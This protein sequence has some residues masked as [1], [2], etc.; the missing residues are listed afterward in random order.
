MLLNANKKNTGSIT[1]RHLH[2][3][4]DYWT[5]RKLLNL[6]L[7]E[8]EKRA[9]VANP[10]SMPYTAT[11]D[12]TNAC[13]LRCPG[14]PTGSGIVGRPKQMLEMEQLDRFL[15]QTG[16]YLLMAHLFNWGESLLHPRIA[17][18]VDRVHR[19]RIFTTISSNLNIRGFDVIARVCDAGLDHLIIS[20]DGATAETY[21]RYRVGGDFE[22]V[23]R[24][25][26][27]I[28]EHRAA[29]GSTRPFLEWQ[30]LS[31]NYLEGEIE[32]ARALAQELG[33]DSFRIKGPTAPERLQ[34]A[35]RTLQ[36][37]FYGGRTRCSLLWHN[38]TLQADGGLAACCNVYHKADD[39]G[40]LEGGVAAT[41]GN[42]SWRTA[43]MLFD[44]R[45]LPVLD[46]EL[47]HPC[48]RCPVV[49]RT[50]HLADYLAANPNAH[51]DFDSHH[52]LLHAG[53]S[54]AAWK[55]L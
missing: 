53:E 47:D 43:R 34:P 49:H 3:L 19:R 38:V 48:L 21:R 6:L 16:K 35:T 9:G 7:C 1:P 37:G 24:N 23:K 42:E 27:G 32:A 8:A 5:P 40:A 29:R 54:S 10:R 18:I 22:L 26:R 30:I 4:R 28:V 33:V 25:I 14:C 39:F 45:S 46:P 12:V 2:A 17:E 51:A 11:I 52:V 55:K 36:G 41:R 31:F 13:N 20:A 44:P 15:D 50:P